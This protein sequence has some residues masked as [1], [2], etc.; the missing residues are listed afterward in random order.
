MPMEA[1][2]LKAWL[3]TI[4]DDAL[5]GLAEDY[6]GLTL[7]DDPANFIECGMALWS[8]EHQEELPR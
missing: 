2:E 1:R 7:T 5:V 4:P 3:S 8:L 6:M